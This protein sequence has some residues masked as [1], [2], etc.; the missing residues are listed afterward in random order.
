MEIPADFAPVLLGAKV[1]LAEQDCEG[2]RLLPQL[3]IRANC[4]ASVPL[5]ATPAIVSAAVPEFVTVK[6][7]ATE[8]API[9]WLP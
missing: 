6:V 5:S 4:P 7:C 2:F 9:F 1:T 3:L 8:L